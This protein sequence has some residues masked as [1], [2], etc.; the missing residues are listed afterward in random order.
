M[1]RDPRFGLEA[2]VADYA[3]AREATTALNWG[4]KE[5]QPIN[6]LL[7][8]L[9][10]HAKA[11]NATASVTTT[12]TPPQNSSSAIAVLG[13]TTSLLLLAVF[14]VVNVAVLRLR[15]DLQADGR[16]DLE[17]APKANAGLPRPG[18]RHVL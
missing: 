4:H 17:L 9:Y 5:S 16:R 10:D 7:E 13:G 3:L 8:S 14:A 1:L 15:R 2:Y 11:G 6:V 18:L 12:S